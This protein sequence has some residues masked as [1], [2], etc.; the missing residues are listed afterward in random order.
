[1]KTLILCFIL[2]LFIHTA[3]LFNYNNQNNNSNSISSATSYV[4]VEIMH[5]SQG[6]KQAE[7]IS[8]VNNVSQKKADN[9]IKKEI[10][11]SLNGKSKNIK[12][13]EKKSELKTAKKGNE[14]YEKTSSFINGYA[15]Y[16]PE[17]KY[18]L[19]SRRNKEEGS[20]IFNIEID[21]KG[22]MT[23]YKMVQSSGYKRLD[24]EAEKSLKTAKFQPALKNG[25][26]VN[27]NFDLKITFTLQGS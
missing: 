10:D 3:L 1:M 13:Q 12:K 26:P 24:K 21:K 18:P 9:N 27:S 17:P 6:V 25:E 19:L 15:S 16:V 4:S 11:K 14:G 2:S 22:N 20:I 7:D 23:A 8:G 5:L